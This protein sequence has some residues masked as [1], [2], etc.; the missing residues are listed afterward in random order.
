MENYLDRITIDEAV[1]NGKPTIRGYRITVKTILEYLAAGESYDG[2][3]EAYSFLEEA[4]I[5][6]CIQFAARTMDSEHHSLI[7]A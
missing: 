6:A 2:I 5:K 7:A 4:D 3:L 1:C